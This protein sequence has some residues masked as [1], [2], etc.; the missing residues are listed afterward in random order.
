[1]NT[2]FAGVSRDDLTNP[3]PGFGNHPPR[4]RF[5]TTLPELVLDGE[6]SF[7]WTARVLDAPDDLGASSVEGWGSIP[8]PS[9]YSMP[10]HGHGT[11]VY[12]NVVYPFAVEPPT[13]PEDNPVGDHR[14]VF[15]ASSE[16][17]GGALLRFDG[18][19]SAGEVWLN[20]VQLGTTRGSRLPTEFDVSGIL[21]SVS[22]VLTVRVVQFS[23]AS[24]IEDQDMWWLPGLF[25]SVTLLAHPTG[26]IED[27]FVQTAF[28][29]AGGHLSV[30]L[31]G[32]VG[33]KMRIKTLG[34]DG[35]I[36][37]QTIAV[38]HAEP[39]SAEQPTLYDLEIVTPLET[40]TIP[41]GFRTVSVADSTLLLN[42]R[43]ILLRGVN[44]H[45]HHPDFGRVVPY[46]TVVAE[47]HLM[48]QHNINAIRTS[49][50]PPHPDVLE[51]ADRLGF[52]LIDECDLETHGF[53]LNEWRENPSNDPAFH[54]A[55]LDRMRRMVERDKNH[56]S[57]LFW[58][59]GNEAG[60]GENLE[61]MAAWAKNRD[62]SRLIHYEGDQRS[63]FVDVYSRMYASHAETAAIGR[64]EEESLD[65][66]ALDSHRRSLPFL[67]CEY[68]HAMGNGPGGLTEYQS[69]FE[70]YPRL[71]GG[72]VW[73][74][75]EHGIRKSGADADSGFAYGGDFGEPLHDGAFVI[76]GLVSPNRI[77]RPGLVDFK[78][79]IEPIRMKLNLEIGL[80]EIHN[81]YDFDDLHNL[82]FDWTSESY[83][84]AIFQGIIGRIEVAPRTSLLHPLP[85]R[86][87]AAVAEG[88]VVTLSA[89]LASPSPWA[90]AGHEIA[91][92][93]SRPAAPPVPALD[94]A[95]TE[96]IQRQG[97][98]ELGPGIFDRRTGDLI[99]FAGIDVTGPQVVLWRAPTDNDLGMSWNEGKSI[100]EEQRWRESGLDRLVRRTIEVIHGSDALTVTSVI[101]VAGQDHRAR[102][103]MRWSSD[104]DS[105]LFEFT[106]EPE[107][108][109]PMTLPRVG[110]VLTLPDRFENVSWVGF[111]PGQSYPDT[112]QGQRWGTF[113]HAI[114]DLSVDYVRPQENGSRGG[115]SRWCLQDATGTSFA[116]EGVNLQVSSRV[117]STAALTAAR[118][119]HELVPD[120]LTHLEIDFAQHGIGTAACGAGPLPA[121][122]LAPGGIRGALRLRSR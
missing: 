55:L 48:K 32:P 98:I 17:Q 70:N 6:W 100:S 89:R 34:L 121:F 95:L 92:I 81:L 116:V 82:V 73:E 38:E 88:G 39:W 19:D 23:A 54:D 65:D 49:H 18:I 118:H 15:D 96:C 119:S 110:V 29:E 83:S 41:I 90:D 94:G 26:S 21:R 42:G 76:D 36:A 99:Q 107:G 84:G 77:P 79:V 52:Y 69:L 113:S 91:W 50:Y 24:Y 40:V 67:L 75:L 66:P 111:G 37:G 58:S 28:D 105:L 20:G 9:S 108:D 61:A 63:S 51:L 101:G 7:R 47:L 35:L 3:G 5:R 14:R 27:I 43:P 122:R 33:A 106:F 103:T 60:H 74:W 62:P 11:P 1:M 78:K 2:T 68:A 97:S 44:R 114:R 46:D 45:E 57:I 93:Q 31:D 12:T 115:V 64:Y 56:P 10:I 8:V 53:E 120:G 4:A 72:F 16:F 112:G 22:N 102:V 117:W 87:L 59:L 25:R 86:L 80:L 13:P 71:A 30:E 109:W 85:P 104:G